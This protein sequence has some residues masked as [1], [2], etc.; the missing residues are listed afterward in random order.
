MAG[1]TGRQTDAGAP[2]SEALRFRVTSEELAGIKAVATREGVTVSRLLRRAVR[3]MVSGGPDFFD[4]GTAQ[5]SELARELAAIQ[6][7][8]S[9]MPACERCAPELADAFERVMA[10]VT[11][12]RVGFADQVRRSRGRWMPAPRLGQS[13]ANAS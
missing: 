11:S 5:M 3:E 7:L 10:A 1:P 8:L 6:R 2:F 9:G 12:T 4:D 13:S